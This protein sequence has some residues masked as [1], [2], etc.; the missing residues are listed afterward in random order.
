MERRSRPRPPA[1]RRRAVSSFSPFSSRCSLGTAAVTARMERPTQRCSG[2]YSRPGSLGRSRSGAIRCRQWRPARLLGVINPCSPSMLSIHLSLPPA[3]ARRQD[4]VTR[5]ARPR[6]P[7]RSGSCVP[8]AARLAWTSTGQHL[9]AG[10]AHRCRGQRRVPLWHR[11]ST[12]A[13][14]AGRSALGQSGTSETRPEALVHACQ[15]PQ[16]HQ[17]MGL[18]MAGNLPARGYRLPRTVPVRSLWADR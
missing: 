9:R 13:S 11:R 2:V 5:A 12:A 8:T 14:T 16:N 7:C 17:P 6:F 15:P 3:H 10:R 4:G 1:A 18:H